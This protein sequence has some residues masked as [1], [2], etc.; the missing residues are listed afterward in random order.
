[1]AST[2]LEWALRYADLGWPVLPLCW[3][4]E[5]GAC[6]CGGNHRDGG[7]APL[8]PHGLKDASAEASQVI[9]WW[10]RWP[11]ANV[12]IL[13]GERSMICAVD[14]DA[15]KGGF[16]SWRELL[17]EHGKPSDTLEQLTG[18][19]RHLLFR[20]PDRP[21]VPNTAHKLGAGIDTRCDNG[22]IVAAPS[23]HWSGRRYEWEASALPGEIDLAPL[24]DWIYQGM[25]A[26]NAERDYR[27]ACG[28]V[29]VKDAPL[30]DRGRWAAAVANIDRLQATYDGRR[31][32]L[33]KDPTESAYDLALA[34]LL[35]RGGW[36]DQEV[37]DLLVA[38]ALERGEHVKRADY[39]RRTIGR[40]RD[41]KGRD[42]GKE[43]AGRALDEALGTGLPPG[44]PDGPGETPPGDGGG[45]ATSG[46]AGGSG[47][48]LMGLFNRSLGLNTRRLIQRIA[49]AK[50]KPTGTATYFLEMADGWLAELGGVDVIDN[51]AKFCR[52]I[53]ELTG[54]QLPAIPQRLWVNRY[55][56]ALLHPD[57]LVVE[58]L[59]EGASVSGQVAG[60]LRSY[61]LSETIAS[62]WKGAVAA[63][64]R[65]QRGAQPFRMDG[66]VFI[67]VGAFRKW[68]VST[69]AEIHPGADLARALAGYG[70]EL[71]VINGLEV[72]R[73][74]AEAV[75]A[76]E[77]IDD[78][79]P[80]E[81]RV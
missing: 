21:H 33:T 35:A 56:P 79:G 65:S 31:K 44:E 69:L 62:D 80:G 6:A 38:R 29:E 14:L 22:Y 77:E 68:L 58:D 45:G 26:R 5:Y 81:G 36:T 53:L 24:P 34:T 30:V 16:D 78:Q 18:S 2:V 47:A 75:P 50:G 46:G 63:A 39:Y 42:D 4:D 41:Y 70:A 60:W 3:P 9:A 8:T 71:R 7:K 49:H 1:M 20:R 57:N 27:E 13:T 25:M 32:D 12:G 54:R 43:D 64:R 66:E 11:E 52:R 73:A 23:R 15:P 59:G 10:R 61:L 67:V 28:A 55:Q 37:C 40:A 19:G 72:W 74:P 17:A 48:D 76:Q 51:S